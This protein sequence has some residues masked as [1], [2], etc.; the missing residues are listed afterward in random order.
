MDHRKIIDRLTMA[1]EEVQALKEA[2]PPRVP[3]E[4]VLRLRYRPGQKV[5]DKVT[6]LEGE[7]IEGAREV[8]EV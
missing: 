7:V 2:P 6:G 3:K 4:R 5:K 1:T 8:I